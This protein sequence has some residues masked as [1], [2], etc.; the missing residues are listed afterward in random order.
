MSLILKDPIG[1]LDYAIDW[2]A[3][4]L[5]GDAIAESSWSVVPTETGGVTIDDAGSDIGTARVKVS[6]G[7]AGKTYRLLNQIATASGREDS[8]SILI[9]VEV[10]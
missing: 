4:Y 8:R 10:R 6:G 3:T 1:S 5:R 9:R 7:R 2:G